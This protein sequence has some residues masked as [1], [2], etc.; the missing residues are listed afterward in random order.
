MSSGVGC[1]GVGCLG[2]GLYSMTAESC[3]LRLLLAWA[4]VSDVN[5]LSGG[6][7]RVFV[8]LRACDSG[9]T[10]TKTVSQPCA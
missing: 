1:L 2:L 7:D 10:I 5:R 4:S 8:E 6:C 3:A 9:L